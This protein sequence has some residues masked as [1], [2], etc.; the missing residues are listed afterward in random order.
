MISGWP[1]MMILK[2]WVKRRKTLAALDPLE[3][4]IKVEQ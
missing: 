4:Q 2:A 3:L 1:I